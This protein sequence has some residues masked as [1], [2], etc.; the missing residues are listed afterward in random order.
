MAMDRVPMRKIR[1]ILRLRWEQKLSVRE[2]AACVDLSTGVVGKVSQ[3]AKASGLSWEQASSLDEVALERMLYGDPRSKTDI[4]PK[5]EPLWMHV[6]LRRPGVTLELLHLE[7]LEQNPSGYQYTAFCEV[8]RRWLKQRGLTMRQLHKAGERMFTDFSGKKPSIVDP[9]TGERIE[10]ELFVAVQ[11]ASSYTY[12]QAMYTQQLR[13]WVMAHEKAFVYFGGVTELTV[14][15]QLKSAVTTSCRYEPAIQ[16]T[17]ADLARHYDTSVYPAR[18]YKPRDKAKVE[19]GVQV[20]QR[21]ILARLRNETFF[22]LES[23]NLRIE[24]L[25]RDLNARPMKRY[26][27]LSRRDLF[28]QLDRPLL[29][30]LPQ[31]AYE[32]AE[33]SY[34]TVTS[35]YHVA[36]EGHFYSVPHHLVHERVEL[37]LTDHGVEVYHLGKRV[38]SHRRSV[39]AGAATTNTEHMPAHHQAWA[40]RSEDDV[41]SRATM[42]GPMVAEMVRR[43][44]EVNAIRPQGLRVAYGLL[45]LGRRY[46][47]E[48]LGRAC[49]TA[50]QYGARSYKPVERMLRLGLEGKAAAEDRVPIA[51][52]NIRG[53]DY[54]LH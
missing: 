12:A 29:R 18:P 3:R 34:A 28:E 8:Y 53:P 20:V 36:S 6:E 9:R 25:L 39:Q 47:H 40:N 13:D 2:T 17:F 1:E 49:E 42:M 51:H 37:R 14:P 33:W 50:V 38:A 48:R 11:G 43:I 54:Y 52:E 32:Y 4:K 5:P 27:G 41:L 21:W 30:P 15:D 16:S 10:L 46:S 7:Y 26:G 19:V 45:S 31:A 44:L 22:S 24:V 35:D 23:L